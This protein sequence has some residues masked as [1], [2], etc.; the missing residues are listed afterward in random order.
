MSKQL[1]LFGSLAA[2]ALL[3]TAG[4][5]YVSNGQDAVDVR[6]NQGHSASTLSL[7]TKPRPELSITRFPQADGSAVDEVVMRDGTTKQIIYDKSLT[8]RHVSAF[9]KAP[10]DQPRGPLMYTKDHDAMG[11]L[12]AERHLR[13]DGSLEMDGHTNP[14]TTYVR[15]FYFAA[16]DLPGKEDKKVVASEQ[17]FD[18]WWHPTSATDFRPDSTR[19]MLHTWGDGL[20]EAFTN[21][22]DDGEKILSQVQ[23]GRGKYYTAVYYPD[24]VNIEVEALNT[25]E[26]TTFQWYRLDHS[27]KLKLTLN[28][29]H[30]DH[31]ILTDDKGKPVLEQVWVQD[32]SL[33]KVDGQPQKRLLHIN[34]I[35]DQGNVD[36]RY[37]FDSSTG[38][39]STVTDYLGSEVYG[40]RA[41]YKIVD[42]S[43]ASTVET[44]DDSGKSDG[45]KPVTDAAHK[46]FVLDKRATTYPQYKLPQLKDGLNLYGQSYMMYGPH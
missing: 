1:F 15:H 13:A 24:G 38:Q 6:F 7:P 41:E 44:Y 37:D 29:A 9:Y 43:A 46:Q 26:G 31:L 32:L 21:F 5:L 18:K 30:Q 35:N 40:A 27:L 11:H 45:G 8:L 23:T 2:A 19:K 17:L 4:A 34:R 28:P 3:A 36:R 20:D 16:A 12:I 14:D 25:Y 10:K 42:G 33:P 22:A 39:L